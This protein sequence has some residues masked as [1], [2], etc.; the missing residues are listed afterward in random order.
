MAPAREPALAWVVRIP[1]GLQTHA[2]HA[3][4]CDADAIMALPPYYQNR[5]PGEDEVYAHYEA[6]APVVVCPGRD[7]N[8]HSPKGSGF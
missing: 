3:Q 8:P 2:R 4:K 6:M 1:A 5:I 7:S